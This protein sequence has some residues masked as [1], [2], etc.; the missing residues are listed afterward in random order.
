[1]TT[2][3]SSA[4]IESGAL[5]VTDQKGAGSGRGTPRSDER[6]QSRLDGG[7]MRQRI[8][9]A[10]WGNT[11]LGPVAQWPQSLRSALSICLGSRFP[12]VIYWG[13]ALRTFYNDAYAPILA[14]KHPWALGRPCH[15]VWAEIWDVIGPQ[16]DGV[17]RTSTATWADDQLLVLRRH[18]YPEECYFSFSFSAIQDEAG[19][20]G[21]V[22]TAVTENTAHVVGKRRLETLRDLATHA[23]EAKSVDEACRLT[24][25]VLARNPTDVPF[26]LIYLLEAGATVA[27]LACASGVSPGELGAPQTVDLTSPLGRG[28][29]PLAEA[30]QGRELLVIDDLRQRIGDLP[31]G[32]WPEP[33]EQA[34]LKAVAL[35]TPETPLAFAVTGL[36]SRRRLDAD[37]RTFIEL[38]A[39][40]T[41]SAIANASTYAAERR[42]AEALAELDRAK[43]AFFSNVSHE[44]RTPLTLMLGPLADAVEDPAVAAAPAVRQSLELSLTL[45]QVRVIGS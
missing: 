41:A 29:W 25:D 20:L 19:G 10:D 16:L 11:P 36:S 37:Y 28:E 32:P 40:H 18:G 35:S 15:E 30:A 7:E 31:G 17:L 9:T 22:F 6:A 1:L 12:I 44:F 5:R 43:T 42:R 39:G 8:D 3:G 34:T 13:D 27:R 45:K 2:C 26:C 4:T 14:A 38:I 33:A 23:A 24:T 21:G